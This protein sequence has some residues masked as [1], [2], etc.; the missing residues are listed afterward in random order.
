MTLLLNGL[1]KLRRI[2]VLPILLALS[3][4]IGTGSPL[5]LVSVDG[6]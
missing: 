6:C 5:G 2:A 1:L 3:S 4:K